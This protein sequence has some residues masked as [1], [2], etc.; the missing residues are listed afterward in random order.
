MGNSQVGGGPRAGT[1]AMTGLGTSGWNEG[2]PSG[3]RWEEG[4]IEK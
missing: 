3:D 4:R 1:S 2:V